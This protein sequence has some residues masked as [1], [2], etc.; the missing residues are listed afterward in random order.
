[1]LVL[2]IE[3]SCDETAAAVI[4]DVTRIRSN[5][6]SS[7]IAVH[8]PYGGVVP[9]LAS[10]HHIRNIVFVIQQALDEASVTLEDLD[11]IAVTRGPGLVGALLVGLQTAKAMAYAAGLPLIGVNHLEGHLCAPRLVDGPKPPQRHLALLVS[12][13]HTALLMVEDF[14]EYRLLGATRDDAAGE[15]FD[16]IAKLLGLGYP[17]GPIIEQLARDGDPRAIA[18]PRA[19]P[20]RDEL[21]F[22]FSGLKTAVAN[23]VRARGKPE[24]GDLADLCASFQQ[25]VADVLVRKTLRAAQMHRATAIVASGGV[26]ANQAIRSA[27]SAATAEHHCTLFAPPLALCTDNAAMIAVAGT[28]RLQLGQ[29]HGLDLNAQARL[30]L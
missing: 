12:G 5:V 19:L 15:A 10:R 28:L 13:G 16:K 8:R 2:G 26:L 21:D 23:H 24:G 17:G 7:Q 9:E 20:R 11:G 4:E 1:M 22:S 30:P 29:R 6:V 18:F 25:A 27:L 14:G 3:S